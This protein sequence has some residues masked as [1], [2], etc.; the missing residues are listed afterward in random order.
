MPETINLIPQEERIQQTKTKVVKLSTILAVILLI[1]AA[2][3]GGY[4]YYRVYTIKQEISDLDGNITQLRSD[5][6]SLSEIEV[7]ARNLFKKSEALM[8]L[9]DNRYYYSTLL[10]ELDASIPEQVV[11]ESFGLGKENTV[12]ISAKAANYNLVQ[13]FTNKLLERDI[14]TE[15]SLNSVGLESTEV[16][17][18]IVVSYDE[19]FLHE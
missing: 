9:F 2:G 19:S 5:I 13:D 8:T 3:L 14:F 17:F 6:S 10:R 12:A 11:I 15:V 4:F 7:N 18:F 16:G 1:I